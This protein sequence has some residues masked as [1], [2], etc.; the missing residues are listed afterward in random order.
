MAGGNVQG[1][2]ISTGSKKGPWSARSVAAYNK[3]QEKDATL[4]GAKEFLSEE[5]KIV[6]EVV[7]YLLGIT[8]G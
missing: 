2:M 6:N 7:D 3:E 8:V 1:G 5:D 4:R